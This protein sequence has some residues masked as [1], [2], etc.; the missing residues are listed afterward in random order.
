MARRAGHEAA[1]RARSWVAL[2]SLLSA[3]RMKWTRRTTQAR[4]RRS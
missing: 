3:A 1:A 4:K 2:R